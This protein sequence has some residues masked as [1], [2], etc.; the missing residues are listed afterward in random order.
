MFNNLT[1]KQYEV[2]KYIWEHE[3][4]ISFHEICTL[5]NMGE[6]PSAR[7][8]I[9]DHLCQLVKKEFVKYEGVKRKRLYYPLV[10]RTEY[11]NQLAR[12]I[13]DQLFGGSLKNF[14]SAFT[15]NHGLTEREVIALKALIRKEERGA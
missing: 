3:G 1:Q 7:Q 2:M 14:V 12:H 11:D 10:S 8:T 5:V 13:V 15:L 9:N 4:G 6:D